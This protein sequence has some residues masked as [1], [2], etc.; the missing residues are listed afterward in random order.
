MKKLIITGHIGAN[1]QMRTDQHGN[2]FATFS[3]A[4][5]VGS[6]A[7]PKTDWIDISCTGKL[8]EI[9]TAYARKGNKVL[10]EGFPTISV[11]V[12]QGDHIGVQR[13]Y[14]HSLEILNKIESDIGATGIIEESHALQEAT[15][16]KDTT[17]DMPFN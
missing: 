8:A 9:A 3:V 1:P 5:A 15:E 7:N 17:T 10:V 14:A 4:V 16:S 2:Q 12:N 6:K 13:L 11:Y